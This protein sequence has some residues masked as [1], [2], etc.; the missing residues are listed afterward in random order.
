MWTTSP[1]VVVMHLTGNEGQWS[2]PRQPFRQVWTWRAGKVEIVTYTD[3]TQA[4]EA[5]GLSE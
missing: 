5:V 4:L 2:A 3:P 1:V